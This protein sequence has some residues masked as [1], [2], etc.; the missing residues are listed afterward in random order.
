VS[1]AGKADL[2]YAYTDMKLLGAAHRLSL[3]FLF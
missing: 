1:V 2:D 3:K